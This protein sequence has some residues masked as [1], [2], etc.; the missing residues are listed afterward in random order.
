[1]S[2]ASIQRHQ[3]LYRRLVAITPP[4]HRSRFG[5]EQVALFGDLLESG[6]SPT[7]LWLRSV[8]DLFRVF[9]ENR[10]VMVNHAARLALGTLSLAPLILGVIVGW[11]ATD[12]LGDMPYHIY[13]AAPALLLQG[14]FTLLWLTGRL[15]R[16]QTL[17]TDI[18]VVGEVAALLFGAAT[19]A[20][21]ISSQSPSDPEYAPILLGV[22]VTVHGLIGLL[23]LFTT[24]RETPTG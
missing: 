8:P 16:W 15:S 5:E 11:V 4:P 6:E 24:G 1:M 3:A 9:D 20:G 10:E 13:L 21:A 19:V 12:E 7:R 17:A 18:F 23:A 22:V 14:A 2:P